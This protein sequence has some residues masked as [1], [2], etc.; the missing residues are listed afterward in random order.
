[1]ATVQ[2]SVF[3]GSDERVDGNEYTRCVFTDCRLIYAGG[4]PP[5]FSHCQFRNSHFYFDGPAGAT[6]AFL[7][8]IANPDSGLRPM[9]E[10]IFPTPNKG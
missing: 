9:F 10:K 4:P 2:D 5:S 1:M 7:T 3:M 8:G 6:V